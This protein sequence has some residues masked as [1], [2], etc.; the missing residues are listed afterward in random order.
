MLAIDHPTSE[1]E[2]ARGKRVARLPCT[3]QDGGVWMC[4]ACG[5]SSRAMDTT[6]LRGWAWRTRYSTCGGLGAGLG[7]GNEGVECGRGSDCLAACEVEQEI[8]CDADD[9]AAIEAE[10]AQAECEGHRWQGSSYSVQEVVGIGGVVK[11][12]IRKR[13]SIGAAV[14]EYEDERVGGN[15]LAR[16]QNGNN[17]SF[18]AWCES[19]VMGKRD[20]D[21]KGRS[22]DSIA[23]SSST[24]S[25]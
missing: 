9:I 4:Q 23:S 12:K 17:R 19:V 5:H 18:C 3:C 16:E 22:T 15:F 11:K 1:Y 13:I 20:L 24:A 8:E 25:A 2:P 6:Y 10:M 7:E 21:F 14:K